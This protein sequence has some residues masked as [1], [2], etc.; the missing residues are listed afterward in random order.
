VRAEDAD[1][2]PGKALRALL[3]LA[4]AHVAGVGIGTGRLTELLGAGG[5]HVLGCEPAAEMLV[6]APK[7]LAS[8]RGF[9][10]ETLRTD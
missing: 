6:V 7:R 10:R 3:P 1:G 9:Q 5:A 2:A 8:E 4:G